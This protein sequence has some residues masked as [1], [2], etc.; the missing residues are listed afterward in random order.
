V[1]WLV[2]AIP[3]V[4]LGPVA[5]VEAWVGWWGCTSGIFSKVECSG[6]S[7][8]VERVWVGGLSGG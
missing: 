5:M 4:W 6:S 7:S 8:M 3:L 1:V 2:V